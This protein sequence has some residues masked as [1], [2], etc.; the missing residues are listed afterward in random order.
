MKKKLNNS[1][2]LLIGLFLALLYTSYLF[3]DKIFPTNDEWLLTRDSGFKDITQAYLG[4]HFFRFDDWHWPLTLTDNILYPFKASISYTDSIPWFA[5]FFKLFSNYLP[6][7]FQYIGL[8][9]LL[10][11]TLQ[12]FWGA[13]LVVLFLSNNY[14]TVITSGIL[15]MIAPPLTNRIPH[16]ALTSHWLILASIW[17]YFSLITT[18]KIKKI[19]RLQFFLI[20]ITCGIHPYLAVMIFLIIVASY[21]QLYIDKKIKLK[22]G[23]FALITASSLLIIGWYFFGYFTNNNSVGNQGFGLYSTNLNSLI[24]PM[25]YSLFIN[26]LPHPP[27]QSGGYNYLGLG[28]LLLSLV[29]FVKWLLSPKNNFLIIIK[30]WPI[31]VLTILLILFAISNHIY[32]GNTEILTYTIPSKLENIFQIFRA[33]GRFIWVF[34][35]LLL[36][37]I[38]ST[39]FKVWNRQQLYFILPIII[40]LQFIDL[41]PNHQLLSKLSNQSYNNPLLS[42]EWNKLSLEH[43]KLIVIPAS[44]CSESFIFPIFERLA[45]EQKIQTNTMYLA[46]YDRE[47]Y[48]FHCY[49]LPQLIAYNQLE[50]DAAYIL[51]KKKSFNLYTQIN[52]DERNSHYCSEIDEFIVCRKRLS[53]SEIKEIDIQAQPYSINT[54]LDFQA[55]SNNSLN[56]QWGDWSFPDMEGTWTNGKEAHLF[57]KL[58]EPVKHDAILNIEAVPFINENH[59]Q[60]VVDVLVNKELV[61]QLIFKLDQPLLNQYEIPIPAKL[62]NSIS[63]LQI[64]F[65]FSNLVSPHRVGLGEDKRL[66]GLWFKKMK[67]VEDKTL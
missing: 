55:N 43:N 65:R 6:T 58:P 51:D 39:S 62:I 49:K 40:C 45:A 1:I 38:I 2:I 16:V 37:A 26:S 17:S 41:I 56:Y 35:Y 48:D 5:I 42:Q 28:I 19:L 64:T 44:Q 30:I 50:K 27:Y 53:S 31:I 21:I 3:K 18:Y 14:F 32:W 52:L 8:F 22:Q 24:N 33:S 15:F 25:N 10:S 34:H 13:R 29:T 12:F 36:L 46:R 11:F 7:N 63:P 67:L 4:W 66:L 60:Q 57:M 54:V 23:F 47:A 59:P 9:L 61:T 20:L